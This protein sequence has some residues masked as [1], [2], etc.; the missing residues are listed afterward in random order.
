MLVSTFGC[1]GIGSI[2]YDPTV[3]DVVADPYSADTSSSAEKNDLD[4][5]TYNMARIGHA[6]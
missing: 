3:Y 5:F 2:P 4:I 6:K 1:S